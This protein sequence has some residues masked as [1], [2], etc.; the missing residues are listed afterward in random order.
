MCDVPCF[1]INPS[2]TLM[3]YICAA[4]SLMPQSTGTKPPVSPAL[5][6]Q[7]HTQR[8]TLKDCTSVIVNQRYRLMQLAHT[9]DT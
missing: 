3:R 7:R 2:F 5:P 1:V 4:S 8:M 6:C 9:P